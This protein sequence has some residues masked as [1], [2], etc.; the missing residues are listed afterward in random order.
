MSTFTVAQ[1]YLLLVGSIVLAVFIVQ[2]P[3]LIK[4]HLRKRR[5]KEKPKIIFLNADKYKTR[6]SDIIPIWDKTLKP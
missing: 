3:L 1:S 4:G 2:L 6:D 5:Q